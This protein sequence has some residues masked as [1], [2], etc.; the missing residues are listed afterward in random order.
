MLIKNI[1]LGQIKET[2]ALVVMYAY[3]REEEKSAHVM[4]EVERHMTGQV[5]LPLTG[6][7]CGDM[8][9]AL[10]LTSTQAI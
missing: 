10:I 4:M 8:G 2:P 3:V 9:G 5:Q 7:L 6:Q 1:L